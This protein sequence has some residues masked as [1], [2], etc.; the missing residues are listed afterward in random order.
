MTGEKLESK[1][2]VVHEETL[3]RVREALPSDETLYRAA[4]FF[5]LLGDTTRIKILNSLFIAEMC[6][7]DIASL[8]SVSRS[9]VSHQLRILR[10]ANVVRTRREGKTVYYRLSDHHVEEIV[11]QGLVHTT[12]RVSP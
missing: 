1:T 5:K 2:L 12:E 6:V 7:Y 11:V 9:A 4:D 8:L 3:E 10:Q